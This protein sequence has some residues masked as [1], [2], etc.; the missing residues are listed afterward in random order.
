MEIQKT[1]IAKA[2]SRKKNGTRGINLPDFRLYYKATVLKTVCTGTKTEI[3]P[4]EQDRKPKDNLCTYGHLIIDKGGKNIQWG[5]D[6]LFNRSCW[7]NWTVEFSCSVVSHSL[8]PHEPQHP[9]PPCQ[10]RVYPNSCPLRQ[11]CHPTISSSVI[12]FSTF[13]QSISSSGSFQMSQLFASS[14]QSIEFQL[15]H[16]SFQWT[17]RT[18]FL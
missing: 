16:Q 6:S 15:Q 17:P 11:W 14:G 1:W 12:H 9:R 4:M 2:I 5:K 13:L 10:L 3:R 8:Q 18:D 7:E